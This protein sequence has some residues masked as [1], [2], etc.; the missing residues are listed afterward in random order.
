VPNKETFKLKASLNSSAHKVERQSR[1]VLPSD[2]LDAR[3]NFSNYFTT[4]HIS[5]PVE[6]MKVF[7][8]EDGDTYAFSLR[9]SLRPRLAKLSQLRRKWHFCYA[10]DFLQINNKTTGCLQNFRANLCKVFL[11]VE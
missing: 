7:K 11:D 10:K 9:N 3:E 4:T 5:V 6:G 2:G 8:P 1:A